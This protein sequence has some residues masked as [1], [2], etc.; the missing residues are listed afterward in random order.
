MPEENSKE[1]VMQTENPVPPA[2]Q[3]PV[4]QLNASRSLIKFILLGIITFGIYI[5][6]TLC[7]VSSDI[8]TIASRYDGRKTMFYL[9]TALLAPLTLG[10]VPLIWFHNVS[11]RM[12]IEL[13]RRN[14]SYNISASDFWLWNVLGS[15]III[16][17][18][19]YFH[20]LL[21]ASNKLAAHY[22]VNG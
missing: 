5:L 15:L 3:A 13:R 14:I 6:V 19:I 2:S 10:I 8:N 9:A 22:N 21:T 17:P 20:K 7:G 4:G 12:G 16:G 1:C 11:N 18:F